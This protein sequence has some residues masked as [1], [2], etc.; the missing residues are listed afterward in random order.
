MQAVS[1]EPSWHVNIGRLGAAQVM[2]GGLVMVI[3]YLYIQY[4]PLRASHQGS[5]WAIQLA[6]RTQPARQ[7][8]AG[9][10]QPLYLNQWNTSL[11]S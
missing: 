3:C 1:T 9:V 6:I 2:S 11:Y 10:W 5:V 7:C 4:L 8:C